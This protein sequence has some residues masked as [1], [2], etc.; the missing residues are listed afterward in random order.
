[1]AE[2]EQTPFG[3]F[4]V[5]DPSRGLEDGEVRRA[6]LTELRQVDFTDKTTGEARSL[7]A[8]TFAIENGDGTSTEV[9]AT[10]STASGPR[11]KAFKWL[12]ALMG[13]AAV[14][15]NAYIG[16]EDLIGREANVTVELNDD[17]YP[18]VTAVT[19]LPKG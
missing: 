19:A 1:M 8:W 7:V 5:P 4:Q 2:A 11:S 15:P 14:Q 13:S 10:S 9:E 18:K 17:G 12:V 6:T 16:A 3:G